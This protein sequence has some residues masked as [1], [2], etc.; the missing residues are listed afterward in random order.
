MIKME[1]KP[2]STTTRILTTVINEKPMTFAYVIGEDISG[3]VCF[4]PYQG[5]TIMIYNSKIAKT[6]F[7]L[8]MCSMAF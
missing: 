3:T 2:T 4:Y 8:V 7:I 5:G 6:V 1:I